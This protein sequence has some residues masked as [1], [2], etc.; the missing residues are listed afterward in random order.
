MVDIPLLI[1]DL[2]LLLLIALVVNLLSEKLRVPYRWGLVIVSLGIGF[3]G[4]TPEARL[5][6]QPPL[7]VFL[8]ALLFVGLAH[9]KRKFG[10]LLLPCV[11]YSTAKG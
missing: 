3:V 9:L 8:P 11:A 10:V 7:F 1:C 5:L 4:L 2:V 6:P